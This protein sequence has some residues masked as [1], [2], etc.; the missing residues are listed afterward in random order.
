VPHGAALAP[1]DGGR[2]APEV[3]SCAEAARGGSA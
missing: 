2:P 3:L 1:G